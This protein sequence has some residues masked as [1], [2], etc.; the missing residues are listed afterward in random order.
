MLVFLFSH[1]GMEMPIDSNPSKAAP[2]SSSGETEMEYEDPPI[3][4]RVERDYKLYEWYVVIKGNAKTPE[5]KLLRPIFPPPP[6]HQSLSACGVVGSTIY[7]LGGTEGCPM[8]RPREHPYAVTVD[9]LHKMYVFGG[10]MTSP[11]A[12]G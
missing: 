11:C 4:I 7:V 9:D 1:A 2:V 10:V 3:Y 5:G 8:R 12:V 6:K